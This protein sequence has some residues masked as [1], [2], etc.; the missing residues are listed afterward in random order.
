[1]TPSLPRSFAARA[2]LAQA[3]L[4][5]LAAALIVILAVGDGGISA[6]EGAA[7]AALLTVAAASAGLA[8]WTARGAERAS[9]AASDAARRLADGDPIDLARFDGRA[10]ATSPTPSINCPK[11]F[12]ET[13]TTSR[14]NA[15]C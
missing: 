7:A 14:S 4:A 9:Q 5:V 3:A 8:L 6:V 12:A 2:A 15:V 13:P 1:M 11:P 10:R